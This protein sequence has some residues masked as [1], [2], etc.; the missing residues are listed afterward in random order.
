MST[1]D[2]LTGDPIP[3]PR[4]WEIHAIR[5]LVD[6]LQILTMGQ[7]EDLGDFEDRMYCSWKAIAGAY[8]PNDEPL[9][10]PSPPEVNTAIREQLQLLDQPPEPMEF[11]A[12]WEVDTN[13]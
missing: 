3:E 5:E 9:P 7:F 12:P 4:E 13:G 1:F 8:G 10:L 2:L 6:I 11:I